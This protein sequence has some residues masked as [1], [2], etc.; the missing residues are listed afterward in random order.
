MPHGVNCFTLSGL[1]FCSIQRMCV[2][3]LKFVALPICEIIGVAKKFRVAGG[4]EWYS[5][6]KHWR[7]PIGPPSN[8]I[9][10]HLRD[11]AVFVL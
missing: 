4:R 7:V 10:M 1:L 8:F 2:Q 6:K 11:I 5:L 3:N 9:L